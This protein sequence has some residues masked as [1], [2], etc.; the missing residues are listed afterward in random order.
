MTDVSGQQSRTRPRDR[1]IAQWAR[2]YAPLPGIPD[3][4]LG[5][6]GTPRDVW[7]RFF[8]AFAALSPADIQRRFDAADRHLHE[9]GVTYRAPGDAA[10][11][12][13]PLSHVPLLIDDSEWSEISAG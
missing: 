5:F 1:R 6:D 11:R 4:F 8:D 2:D 3:E 9:A 12:D 13:W 7:Q 10:A